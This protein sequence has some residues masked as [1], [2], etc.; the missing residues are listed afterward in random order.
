M[1]PTKSDNVRARVRPLNTKP[2]L[3]A[4][5]SA[6][7]VI[8]LYDASLDQYLAAG[9]VRL[10]HQLADLFQLGCDVGNEQLIGPRID[11]GASALRQDAFSASAR[12][13]KNRLECFRFLIIQLEGFRAHGL[14]IRNLHTLLQHQKN[15]SQQFI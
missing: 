15:K 3:S 9:N 5:V 10:L 11:H 4:K 1:L 2:K 7:G 6:E 13:I 12:I 8:R 14:K